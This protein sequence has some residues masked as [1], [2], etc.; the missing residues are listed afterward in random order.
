MQPI[1]GEKSAELLD[2][3]VG[4][5]TKGRWLCKREDQSSDLQVPI[6]ILGMRGG[7]LEAQ[8]LGFS[9]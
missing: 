8:D 4:M 5:V 6:R 9:S 7:L 1:V 2:W 3:G